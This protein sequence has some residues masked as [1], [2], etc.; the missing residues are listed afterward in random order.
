MIGK[1]IPDSNLQGQKFLESLQFTVNVDRLDSVVKN[2]N[3][4]VIHLMKMDAQGFECNIMD[5][6]DSAAES[7]D[8]I[9]FEMAGHHL[10]AMGCSRDG[11]LSR[12]RNHGFELY[13]KV[14]ESGFSG[15]L[16]KTPLNNV[17]VDLFAVKKGINVP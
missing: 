2:N 11:L 3:K 9:T 4:E 1:I 16:E 15:L 12:M 14:G 17:G 13:T 5:G 7:I 6:I 10:T 8:I